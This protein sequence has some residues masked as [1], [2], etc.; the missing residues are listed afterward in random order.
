MRRRLRFI[1]VGTKTKHIEDHSSEE[2]REEKKK[3][4]EE[5]QKKKEEREKLRELKKQ[6]EEEVKTRLT[7]LFT[8][9]QS[10]RIIDTS[11][12]S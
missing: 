8:V 3:R 6:Q 7:S 4:E 10:Q 2:E 5:R 9:T 1:V 11:S 12:G